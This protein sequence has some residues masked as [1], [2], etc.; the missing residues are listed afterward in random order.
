MNMSPEKIA[1]SVALVLV[2]SVMIVLGAIGV[3][4]FINPAPVIEPTMRIVLFTLGLIVLIVGLIFIWR[5]ATIKQSNIQLSQKDLRAVA[6][7]IVK[8]LRS[9]PLAQ[10]KPAQPSLSLFDER[11]LHFHEEKQHLADHFIPVLLARCKAYA[12]SGKQVHLIID[13]GTTLFPFFQ[14]LGEATARAYRNR[15]TWIDQLF[16]ETNNIPGV[17]S[18]MEAGRINSNNRYSP[19]AI[20]CDLL[21]GVPLPVYSALTGKKTVAALCKSREEAGDNAVFITLSTGN[22]IRLRRSTPICPIP[23][24]R[25]TGHLEF[26]QA[27]I[28]YSDEIFVV[29]PLAKVFVDVPPGDVNAALEFSEKQT[30]PDLQPYFEV[31]IDDEKAAHVKMVSTCRGSGCV[32]SNHSTRVRAL[33]GTDTLDLGA[34]L[35]QFHDKPIQELPHLIFPFENIPNDWFLQI[36]TEFPHSQTR[37]E[38][39]MQKFFFVPQVPRQPQSKAKGKGNSVKS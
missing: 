3:V 24:A 19:I 1:P 9:E 39:F 8:Q 22:W 30:E 20:N 37:N 33:L 25:G 17:Q 15:E 4:P 32:L 18:L 26:K 5:D 11:K 6:N 38:T 13:S 21:P 34:V 28:D 16:L 27:L 36:A 23:L 14:R 12:E 31:K 29:T 7:E 2:S 10:A 35:K